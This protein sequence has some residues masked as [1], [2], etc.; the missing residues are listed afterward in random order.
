[1]NKELNDSFDFEADPPH[2]PRKHQQLLVKKLLER[3]DSP[4]STASHFLVLEAGLGKSLIG[5]MYALRFAATSGKIKRIVWLTV[6]GTVNTLVNEINN[7]WRLATFGA[8]RAAARSIGASSLCSVYNPNGKTAE[9]MLPSLINVV[10]FENFS[11]D[12]DTRAGLLLQEAASTFFVGDEIH[13]LFN[14]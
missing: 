6:K 9:E 8:S 12:N 13:R 4:V 10:N 11:H 5:L 3:D 14:N 1:M 2:G 7:V